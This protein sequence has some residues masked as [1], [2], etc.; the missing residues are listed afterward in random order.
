[1][2][3]LV[4]LIL[5]SKKGNKNVGCVYARRFQA[6]EKIGLPPFGETKGGRPLYGDLYVISVFFQL[7][8]FFFRYIFKF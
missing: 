1:M 3:T 7:F 5:K 4:R 6:N 2:K 8:F